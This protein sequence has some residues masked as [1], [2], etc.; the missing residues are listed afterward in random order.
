M[1]V[2]PI[3]LFSSLC[4]ELSMNWPNPTLSD[5]WGSRGNVENLCHQ[6]IRPNKVTDKLN[7]LHCRGAVFQPTDLQ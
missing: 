5:I 3:Q 4:D 1:S 7:L 2:I 6:Q